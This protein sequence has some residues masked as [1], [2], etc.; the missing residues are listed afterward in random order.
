MIRIKTEKD[1]NISLFVSKGTPYINFI[2]GIKM[3]VEGLSEQTGMTME[4]IFDDVRTFY[5]REHNESK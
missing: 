3:L 1:G 2:I 5:G 4:D